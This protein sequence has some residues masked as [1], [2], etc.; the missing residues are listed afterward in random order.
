MLLSAALLVTLSACTPKNSAEPFGGGTKQADTAA[1]NLMAGASDQ[2]QATYKQRCLSCH[3]NSLE[4]KIGPKTNLQ[5]IGARLT[6]EQIIAQI[7]KGGGGM[8]GFAGQLKPEEIDGL[9]EWLAGK[10]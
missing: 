9:A 1:A 5:K 4:G 7:N 6:K 2:V 10:K 8:P 3:G